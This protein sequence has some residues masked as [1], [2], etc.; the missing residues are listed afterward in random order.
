MAKDMSTVAELPKGYRVIPEE[1]QAKAKVFFDRGNSVAGTGNYEYAIEMYLQGLNIDPENVDAHQTLREFSLKRKASGGKDLGMFEK[2]K[3]KTNSADEKANMLAAEKLL[4]YDPGNTAR[5]LQVTQS[6]LKAGFFDT[7]MW[8]GAIT[9]RANAES[10]KPDYPTYIA[11]KNVYKE[12]ERWKEAADAAKF[13]AELRP[14]DMDLA[15]ERKNLDTL[16]TMDQGK[17]G[18]A[19]SFRDSIRD[20]DSQRKLL[21]QDK[22][23][24]SDDLMTRAIKEAEAE[25][26]AEPNEP[27]K[28]SKY[29]DALL[30]TERP[31]E[32]NRA[33]EVLEEAYDRTKQFRWRQRVGQIKIAQ[34]NRMDRSMRDELAKDKNNAELKQRYAEFSREK[35]ETE[36]GEL[37][38]WVEAYP[39]DTRFRF[40][41]AKRLFLLGR[42]D[43]A[44]PVFQHVRNDPKYRVEA[45]SFLGR[46]FL[47]N[48]FIEEAVET[49]KASIDD[50]QLRGDE[51]SKDMYYWYGRALE[52]QPDTAAALK[53]YSQVAQW[54]FNFRDVQGRIRNLRSGPKPPATA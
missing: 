52:E 43:E 15:A 11:L 17:Y 19:K 41:M 7:V 13:A 48:K 26:T 30:K 8:A 2:M 18:K 37:T 25:W 12:L 1:E 14:D 35:A 44:I 24:R 42:F 40:E 47:E 29:V 4:A 46:A 39:T 31:E 36:L 3:V 27:G 38:Q 34:L 54:D 23:V 16:N 49:L 45:T 22:D 50:Y 6:A 32:E 53:A 33:I 21:D 10:K 9:M 28:L 5:M 51:K 20:M